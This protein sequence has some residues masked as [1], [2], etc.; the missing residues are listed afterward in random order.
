MERPKLFIA[1]AV[2]LLVAMVG[3]GAA[4]AWISGPRA[5]YITFSGP[6]V[7]P[8]VTLPAGTYIFEGA[9]P[10]NHNDL[11]RVLARNRSKVYLLG[12]TTQ[13]MRPEGMPRDRV[14]LFHESREG[15]APRIDAWFP[16][17]ESI[18]HR[19]VY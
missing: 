5:T 1:G 13:V 14:I 12:F 3:I 9:D 11:V 6:V 7:L 2:V 19:F 15:A 8:G 18:G 16:Q 10:L 17:D 4:N